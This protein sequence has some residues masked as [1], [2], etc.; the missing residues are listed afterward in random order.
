MQQLG[1]STIKLRAHSTNKFLTPVPNTVPSSTRKRKWI[2]WCDWPANRER[3]YRQWEATPSYYVEV[4]D[5]SSVQQNSKLPHFAS[6]PIFD[7]ISSMRMPKN[8]DVHSSYPQPYTPSTPL[9]AK[10]QTA[11]HAQHHSVQPISCIDES[12]LNSPPILNTSNKKKT[13][14]TISAWQ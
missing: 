11:F 13:Y 6:Q 5:A 1:F 14:A 12:S 8:I 9:A 7:H 2:T 3:T 4:F 10:R